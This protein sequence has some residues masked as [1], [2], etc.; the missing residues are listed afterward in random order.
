MLVNETCISS[1]A[2]SNTI[3]NLPRL[4]QVKKKTKTSGRQHNGIWKV[5][6]PHVARG[7]L[8]KFATTPN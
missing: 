7:F 2:F 6:A 5:D 4:V 8:T 1:L 3:T